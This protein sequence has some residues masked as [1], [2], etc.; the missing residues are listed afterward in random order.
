M[1]LVL[2]ALLLSVASFSPGS[3][4]AETLG[5]APTFT[6]RALSDVDNGKA[7][8]RRIWSPGL[9]DGFVPQGLSWFDGVLYVSAYQSR[10]KAISRGPC[11]L[12]RLDPNSGAV[13]GFLDLP[14]DCGHAGG[15][16][17]AAA[18]RL[19]VADTRHLFLVTLMGKAGQVLGQVE[20]TIKLNGDV[21]GSFA[22]GGDGT[23]WLG[24][25]KKDATGRIYEFSVKDLPGEIDESKALRSL[26]L[27]LRSQGAAIDRQ[28][29]LW[30][31]QSS[32]GFGRISVL[33]VTSGKI[34]R[35]YGTALGVE[36]LSFDT[37]GGLWTVSEA[38]SMRWNDWHQFFPVVYR[39]DIMRLE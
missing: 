11:R 24:S 14:S 28:G 25:Y 39:L 2:I 15:V 38:G 4:A 7:I 19:F 32:G 5:V 30:V 36:D 34:L 3:A 16:A 23:I 9:D 33:D 21:R 29:R 20:R 8:T 18:G 26:E 35:S 22:T 1:R 31:S 12:F 17:R 6:K 13:T 10:D 37:Q 27:P